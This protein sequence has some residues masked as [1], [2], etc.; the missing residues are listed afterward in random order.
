MIGYLASPY[1]D[2]D[3]SVVEKRMEILCRVDAKLM[4]RGIHTVSPLLKHFIILYESLPGDWAY[5]KE[6]SRKLLNIVDMVIVVCQP[7]WKESVGV[8]AELVIAKEL[9]LP[10]TYVN[11]NGDVIE[12]EEDQPT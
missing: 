6:Y 2:P 10:I 4:A 3:P 1:S 9:G 7:G 11:E 5:W 8:Q 12:M